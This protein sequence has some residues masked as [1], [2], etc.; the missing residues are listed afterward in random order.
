MPRRKS[1]RK[2]QETTAFSERWILILTAVAVVIALI[3]AIGT[4]YGV[5]EPPSGHDAAGSA[6]VGTGIATVGEQHIRGDLTITAPDGAPAAPTL[7]GPAAATADVGIANVGRQT[8]DGD[9][10]IGGPSTERDQ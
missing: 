10:N 9:V 3:G 5:V 1:F 6:S 8:I 7:S 2:Q 4:W